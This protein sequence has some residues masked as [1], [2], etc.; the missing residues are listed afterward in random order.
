VIVIAAA[1]G[2][3]LRVDND[4]ALF[5]LP[6]AQLWSLPVATSAYPSRLMVFAFLALAASVALWLA[7][8]GRWRSPGSWA[9]WLLAALALAALAG[10][11]NRLNYA[12]PEQPGFPSFISTGEYQSY[13]A[14]GAV[15]VVISQRGNAGLLWQAQ[16]GSYFRLSG[17]FVNAAISVG[18]GLP[19]PVAALMP[20]PG[21]PPLDVPAFRQYLAD[22]QIADILVEGGQNGGRWPSVLRQ[23]GLLGT[24]AGGVFVYPLARLPAGWPGAPS[25]TGPT[26]FGPD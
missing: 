19:G 20:P 25:G 17:G 21:S 13:I 6:W 3:V 2:P 12:D 7:L 22:N 14:P 26:V 9:R 24:Q 18:D 11:I 8:P 10:N 16:T 4:T 1:L 5:R 15:V 23:A